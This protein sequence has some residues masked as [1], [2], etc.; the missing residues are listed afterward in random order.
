MQTIMLTAV[1]LLPPV[2]FLF[3]VLR[4]DRLEPEPAGLILKA[5][6]LGAAS[7]FP[8]A[9]IE[10][11]VL[12]MPPFTAGGLTGAA[13]QSFIVIAPAEE[14]LKLAA[15]LLFIWKHPAFNEEND[16]IVYT[17][18]AS[19]G[20]AMFENVFYVFQHGI[21]TGMMRAMTSIPMHVFT[22]ILMGYFIGLAKFDTDTG[23]SGKIFTGFVIACII[24]AVYDTFALSGTS[25]AALIIPLV[26]VTII[27]GN[28]ALKKG[29]LLSE[30][31]WG[32]APPR[33]AAAPAA[34]QPAQTAGRGTWKIVISRFLFAVSAIF[35]ALIIIGVTTGTAAA[36]GK[37][38]VTDAILGAVI[39][40]GLPVFIGVILELS[41]KRQLRRV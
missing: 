5:L 17:V 33:A 39:I 6:L 18:A 40:T 13:L 4:N 38:S 15:V 20:F 27:A 12:K 25:L 14:A 30:K 28:I 26:I 8:A 37:S 2:F 21:G 1:A 19:I 22:G 11:V 34:V 7:V 35:W 24:H 41:R 16:G 3:Y 29:R 31:R 32:K 36:K 10:A 9:V 23:G